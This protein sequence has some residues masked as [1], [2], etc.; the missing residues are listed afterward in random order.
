MKLENIL[1]DNSSVPIQT[2]II[3]FGLSKIFTIN[4][5]MQ[6]K[7]GTLL[8][9]PPEIILND[10]YSYKIDIWLFGI[11]AYTILNEGIHPFAEET[12]VEHLL[13]KIIAIKFDYS[14]FSVHY[15][16]I[17]K[18]CLVKEKDRVN[19][20]RVKKMLEL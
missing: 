20:H 16:Y 19:I 10:K 18:S 15:Q 4:E 12:E 1:V 2:K 11:I 9:L 14:K 17:L 5:K 7:Y 3:D 13:Q 8:Y 6:E